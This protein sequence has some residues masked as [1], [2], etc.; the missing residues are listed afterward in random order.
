MIVI[1]SLIALFFLIYGLLLTMCACRIEGHPLADSVCH[2]LQDR[3]HA[4]NVTAI[5][6]DAVLRRHVLSLLRH[7]VEAALPPRPT[8]SILRRHHEALV[9]AELSRKVA[10]VT[11]S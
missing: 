11:A 3:S 9:S 6:E 4:A 1:L 10:A 8:D 7:E 5:P 2:S